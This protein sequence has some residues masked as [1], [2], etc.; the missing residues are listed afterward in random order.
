MKLFED[1][2]SQNKP[3]TA[4]NL[5]QIQDNLVVVSATEP[6]GDNRE[7]VW[8]QNTETEQKIYVKND[9]GV[10]ENFYDFEQLE[11]KLVNLGNYLSY[12]GTKNRGKVETSFDLNNL[13]AGE[14]CYYSTSDGLPTH[15]AG[16]TANTNYFVICM[17]NISTYGKVQI[18]FPDGSTSDN[19][20]YVRFR[21][22]SWGSWKK[23]GLTSL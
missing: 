4:E 16:S 7:K 10:Y 8:V 21:W 11:E 22:S 23:I 15:Y 18:C 12:F 9:N 20:I 19:N 13:P 5:N 14:S 17:N 6:T 3:I 2:P 1:L